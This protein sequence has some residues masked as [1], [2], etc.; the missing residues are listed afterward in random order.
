MSKG[1]VL[2]EEES[3][4]KKLENKIEELERANL[5]L[6]E[7]FS[8]ISSRLPDRNFSPFSGKPKFSCVFNFTIDLELKKVVWL[9][10]GNEVV[11]CNKKKLFLIDISKA[12]SRL[13]AQADRKR[14]K[15]IISQ[16]SDTFEQ[17]LQTLLRV[18]HHKLNFIWVLACF[19]KVIYYRNPKNFLQVQFTKLDQNKE[20]SSL[21]Y[22]FI[23]KSEN[24]EQCQKIE[25]LTGRQRE[26]LTLF[27]KGFTSK[28][29][30]DTLNISFH[31]VEAH[32]KSISKKTKIFKRSALISLAVEMGIIN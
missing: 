22:E 30:A 31:T 7:Y 27:G 28:E 20:L 23:K 32:K 16:Y 3:K 9:S 29:I 19:E 10:N 24:V 14:F 6:Q 4:V 21:Y 26:I 18:Y 13:I 25:L 15:E 1:I 8:K 2:T 17:P 12:T 5:K 11:N